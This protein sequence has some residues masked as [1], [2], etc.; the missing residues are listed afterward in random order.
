MK[1]TYGQWLKEWLNEYKK[2]YI[3]TW[4]N[5]E[6]CIDLHIPKRIKNA[7]F[8]TLTAFDFQKAL[9]AVSSSRMRLETYDIYHGSL[10]IAYK[11]GLC[12]RDI[13]SAL[14]KPKHVRNVGSALTPEELS[15]FLRAIETTR[16]K[17]F[18]MFCLLTG[19]RR[20]EALSV[21]WSD[22]Q[23]ER[24][25]LHIPGTKTELS[26]R[27]IPLFPELKVLL[28]AIPHKGDKIFYHY[29][30]NVTRTFK[31]L[32]PNHKLHDLR[33]TFA[34]RCLECGISLKVVQSWLGH[35]RLDTTASIYSHLLPD[36]IKS[37]SEKFKLFD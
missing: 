12:E 22:V 33:H 4:K 5:I 34:T 10:T 29:A 17:N 20:S 21:R 9:N 1:L 15:D 6:R 27:Y 36:F 35:A 11:V 2:P 31:K 19:C 13:A 30:N 32:C 24:S 8:A 3:K 25:R 16:L 28:S 18:F 26:D 23:S 14:I 37:E 7:Y